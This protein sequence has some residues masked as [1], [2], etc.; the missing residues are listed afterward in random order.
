MEAVISPLIDGLAHGRNCANLVFS[1]AAI[2]RIGCCTKV[3]CKADQPISP[4]F[5]VRDFNCRVKKNTRY[6]N[7]ITAQLDQFLHVFD[8]ELCKL[9]DILFGKAGFRQPCM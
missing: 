9:F 8:L 2:N 7:R 6:I 1:N 5:N 3:V 4:S